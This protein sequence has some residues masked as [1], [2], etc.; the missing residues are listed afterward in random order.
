MMRLGV[1]GQRARKK[2]N[3]KAHI[4]LDIIKWHVL[5]FSSIN[6]PCCVIEEG[7][8]IEKEEELLLYLRES[9]ACRQSRCPTP[10][11][12]VELLGPVEGIMI[13]DATRR[14]KPK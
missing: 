12:L 2:E 11:N 9:V 6:V 14:A 4:L 7:K 10:R 8:K 13:K 1:K 5:D 3:G